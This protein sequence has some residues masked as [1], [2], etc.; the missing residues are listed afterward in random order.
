MVGHAPSVLA[1]VV[2]SLSYSVAPSHAPQYLAYLR[3]I[4][5]SLTLV[6]LKVHAKSNFNLK[7]DLEYHDG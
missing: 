6:K 3:N 5:T 1:R 4:R 7:F 2:I